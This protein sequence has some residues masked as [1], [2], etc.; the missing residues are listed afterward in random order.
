MRIISNKKIHQDVKLLNEVKSLTSRWMPERGRYFGK[1][2]LINDCVYQLDSWMNL[3]SII[4]RTE[5]A[6]N[7][8]HI[9][10]IISEIKQWINNMNV[11][12]NM[13]NHCKFTIIIYTPRDSDAFRL[14]KRSIRNRTVFG[15]KI[16]N[17]I[18]YIKTLRYVSNRK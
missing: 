5:D 2:V 18:E 8:K 12:T 16:Y 15:D 13:L 7:V 17:K 3:F 4:V 14:Y 10:R 6:N 11:N 1:V 9:I